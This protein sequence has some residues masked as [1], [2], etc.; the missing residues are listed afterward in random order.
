MAIRSGR[1]RFNDFKARLSE[2][3]LTRW[4]TGPRMQHG[5]TS[6]SRCRPAFWLIDLRPPDDG[7]DN[8]A[9]VRVVPCERTEP[10]GNL[11]IKPEKFSRLIK[12]SIRGWKNQ[13]RDKR[14]EVC[15]RFESESWKTNCGECEPMVI[16]RWWF[17]SK[18]ETFSRDTK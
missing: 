16:N 11:L 5:S 18:Q 9:R 2:Q 7:S 13:R 3:I 12:L 10:Q 8:P 1:A 17:V 15:R 6:W 4:W 14:I